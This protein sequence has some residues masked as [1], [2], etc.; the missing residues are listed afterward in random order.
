MGYYDGAEMCKLVDTY[1]LKQLKVV[2]TK[3]NMGLYRD[4]GP[5]TFKNIPGSEVK[6]KRKELNDDI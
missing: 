1:L 2:I 6:R 3:Q 4:D 5:G